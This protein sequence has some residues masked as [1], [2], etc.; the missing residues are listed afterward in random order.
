MPRKNL[1]ALCLSAVVVALDQ[2]TKAWILGTVAIT[3]RPVEILPGCFHLIYVENLSAAFG[4]LGFLPFELR[5]YV[6]SGF[7]LAAF[8]VLVFLLASGR[9]QRGW[10]AAAAALIAGGALGNAIDRVRLGHV[11]DFIDWHI[12]EHFHWNT[13]N[14]ADSGIVVGVF[15]LLWLSYR[16]DRQAAA[17]PTGER[18]LSGG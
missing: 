6:L 18:V 3:H 10:T 1:L 11:V 8:C 7:A 16:H 17:T 15:L 2:A 12:A 5:R 13:F 14:V 4:V 9:I